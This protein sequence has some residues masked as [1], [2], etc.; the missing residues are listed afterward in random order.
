LQSFDLNDVDTDHASGRLERIVPG[1]F[2][3]VDPSIA[4]PVGAGAGRDRSLAALSPPIDRLLGDLGPER[5]ADP[6]GSAGGLGP[7]AHRRASDAPPVVRS[8]DP[9]PP[10][11]AAGHAKVFVGF[12]NGADHEVKTS[13]S[14]LER[15]AFNAS[16]P[17]RERKLFDVLGSNLGK[18]RKL[19]DSVGEQPTADPAEAER[20]EKALRAIERSIG[21]AV[22]THSATRDAELAS[23][24]QPV[25]SDATP[26]RVTKQALAEAVIDLRKLMV[27]LKERHVVSGS[28]FSPAFLREVDGPLFLVS[29][30]CLALH[31]GS[32]GT[33]RASG[34]PV[35]PTGWV[36][37]RALLFDGSGLGNASF[38]FTDRYLEAPASLPLDAAGRSAARERFVQDALAISGADAAAPEADTHRARFDSERLK[39]R[40]TG[41]QYSVLGLMAHAARRAEGFSPTQLSLA[42]CRFGEPAVF[43]DLVQDIRRAFPSVGRVEAADGPIRIERG[44][45]FAAATVM[46]YVPVVESIEGGAGRSI[47]RLQSSSTGDLPSL[48]RAGDAAAGRPPTLFTP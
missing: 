28:P 44:K 27:A 33:A 25:D 46:R 26:R 14:N 15:L 34:D 4:A 5:G 1:R 24:V 23:L 41:E 36:G 47:A 16:A 35:Q 11:K 17:P 6:G 3:D 19:R 12:L 21:K 43:G 48:A 39:G 29:H 30:G 13:V 9:I 8:Y 2:A 45:G 7:D 10:L 42:I 38:A 18:L 40:R 31:G 37:A 20:V 32:E 22:S